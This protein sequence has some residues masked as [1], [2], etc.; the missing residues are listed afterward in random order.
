MYWCE[1][2]RKRNSHPQRVKLKSHFWTYF[3]SAYKTGI[4]SPLKPIFDFFLLFK[5][6][7]SH[8]REM[9][10]RSFPVRAPSAYTFTNTN[11][12][13][14]NLI[15]SWQWSLDS[16]LIMTSPQRPK[17][18]VSFSSNI[19]LKF[20]NYFLINT[21]SW[22]ELCEYKQFTLLYFIFLCALILY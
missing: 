11:E 5:V 6:F 12:L 22:K 21:K 20:Y 3:K 16:L 19:S 9:M 1:A 4:N 15:L 10:E 2:L 13:L 7:W 18:K 8:E 14:P 17:P